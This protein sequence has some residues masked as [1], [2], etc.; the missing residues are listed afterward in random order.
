MRKIKR[1]VNTVKA[2]KAY[3][4]KR[5]EALKQRFEKVRKAK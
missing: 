3:K 1:Y 5:R 2:R 4:K